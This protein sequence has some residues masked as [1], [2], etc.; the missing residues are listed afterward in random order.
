M[1]LV[2]REKVES[3]KRR[4]STG[5]NHREQIY[6]AVLSGGHLGVQ[7]EVGYVPTLRNLPIQKVAEGT[8]F[9]QRSEI[10]QNTHSHTVVKLEMSWD[11]ALLAPRLPFIGCIVPLFQVGL[12]HC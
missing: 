5:G 7:M 3:R 4:F 11:N 8:A 1:V 2:L 12:L 10:G 9:V 6:V